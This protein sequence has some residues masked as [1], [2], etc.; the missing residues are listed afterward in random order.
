MIQVSKYYSKAR[1]VAVGTAVSAILKAHSKIIMFQ[2]GKLY[3]K[4]KAKL[5][6]KTCLKVI[7]L[8][9]TSPSSSSP[10]SEHFNLASRRSHKCH[11]KSYTNPD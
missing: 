11:D 5:Y 4:R 7:S 2:T 10:G 6:L 8:W 3:Q 9:K 1:I